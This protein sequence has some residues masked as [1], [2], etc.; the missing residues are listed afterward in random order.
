VVSPALDSGIDSYIVPPR[1]GDD[2]GVCG[3]IALA[4]DAL[5]AS[6]PAE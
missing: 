4:Q 6:C 3:A 5:A 1:L 2:A